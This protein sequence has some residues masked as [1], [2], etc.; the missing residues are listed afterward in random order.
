VVGA[1]DEGAENPKEDDDDAGG[2]GEEGDE[3]LEEDQSGLED[4]HGLEVRTGSEVQH[5]SEVKTGSEVQPAAFFLAPWEDE[6]AFFNEHAL[7]YSPTEPRKTLLIDVIGS[8]SAAMAAIRAKIQIRSFVASNK[9]KDVLYKALSLQVMRELIA[10]DP[11]WDMA[12]PPLKHGSSAAGD[13]HLGDD[14][15]KKLESEPPIKPKPSSSSS[16]SSEDED[17]AESAPKRAR[18]EVFS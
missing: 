5:G 12:L 1:A 15:S 11:I 16:S 10:G 18:M 13:L 14:G 9:H 6:E 7:L 8:F 2:S 4:Q 3:G 17:D